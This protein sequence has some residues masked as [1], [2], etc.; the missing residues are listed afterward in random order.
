MI[1]MLRFLSTALAAFVLA[2]AMLLPAQDIENKRAANVDRMQQETA[3]EL[4]R[5]QPGDDTDVA[6]PDIPYPINTAKLFRVLLLLDGMMLITFAAMA[7]RSRLTEGPNMATALAHAREDWAFLLFL[8]VI[9][10]IVRTVGSDRGLW[11]DEITTLLDYARGS[12]MDVF[13]QASSPNNHP[14]NSFLVQIAI[15]LFGEHEWAVRLPAII[16]GTAT[17]PLFYLL[18]R[19]FSPRV[20]ATLAALTLALSYH[21]VFFS[22]DARGYA[23]MVFGGLLGTLALVEALKRHSWWIW[24]IYSGAMLICVGSVAI[25]AVILAAHFIAVSLLRPNLAFYC[26]FAMAGWL[27]LHVYFFMIPDFLAFT[28][29]L[30][31]RP[32]YGWRLSSGLLQAF[33]QGLRLGPLGLPILAGEAVIITIG[34]VSYVRQDRLVAALLLLPEI[35]MVVLLAALGAGVYPRFFVYA[36]PVVIAFTARGVS[37]I[38]EVLPLSLQRWSYVAAFSGMIA[39]SLFLLRTW[40]LYPMQDY[41]GARHY[42]E[43]Q[44]HSGDAVVAIGTAGVGV[45]YYWP[46][47]PIEN[48]VSAVRELM[49]R[50]PRVWIVYTLTSDMEQRRPKLMQFVRDNFVEQGVFPGMVVG[51]EIH[52]DLHSRAPH[53]A[54]A[55]NPQ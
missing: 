21:H 19:Q 22:Q 53:L 29:G 8:T 45:R 50:N 41:L 38:V 25:G 13:L 32:E 12:A 27:I 7:P 42:I 35:L 36:L 10:G 17:I 24:G 54:P 26:V 31:K 14:L 23:G 2:A 9:A 39:I 4:T 34:I 40:W 48:R 1:T 44:M 28:S 5:L 51:G 52:V 3:L 15:T 37:C 46:Q 6:V 49:D 18:V 16:F 20:E 11:I 43:S 33:A 47:V 55:A 30:Y